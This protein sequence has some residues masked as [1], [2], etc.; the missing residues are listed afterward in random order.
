MDSAA[1]TKARQQE[2]EA[3]KAKLEEIRRKRELQ[4]KDLKHSRLSMDHRQ[5]WLALLFLMW[6]RRYT[7]SFIDRPAKS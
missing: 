1:R 6:R 3:K 2:I 7:D 4:D 5:V